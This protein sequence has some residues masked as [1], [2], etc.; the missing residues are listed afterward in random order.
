MENQQ[1]KDV[2]SM[3]E[4]KMEYME[5]KLMDA[6]NTIE[7]FEEVLINTSGERDQLLIEKV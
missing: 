3:L 4:S 2:I 6:D 5:V 7:K 1:L